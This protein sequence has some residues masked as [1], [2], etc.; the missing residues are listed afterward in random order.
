M[1]Y[2]KLCSSIV[3]QNKSLLLFFQ[4]VLANPGRTVIDK[5]FA[6]D[7]S[8]S[9]GEN[10]IFLTVADAVVTCA[11]KSVEEVWASKMQRPDGKHGEEKNNNNNWDVQIYT[12]T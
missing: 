6:S 1:T 9:I 7:F 8:N 12:P 3:T 10:K 4:L 5:L 2:S 11:P